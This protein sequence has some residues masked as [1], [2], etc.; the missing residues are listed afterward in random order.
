MTLPERLWVIR[1][2]LWMALGRHEAGLPFFRL[3]AAITGRDVRAVDRSTD[4]VIEGFP[5]SANTYALVAFRLAQRHPLRIAHHVHGPSQIWAAAQW[6]VPVL[7]LVREP[8]DA[9]ASLLVR[10]PRLS[11]KTC[12]KNYI[13][14]Y[15]P[16][17]E[18]RGA[19]VVGS[20]KMVTNSFPTVIR[21]LNRAFGTDFLE[22]RSDPDR[23]K[24]IF[25]AI[26]KLDRR[27]RGAAEAS[28][29]TVARPST[30]RDRLLRSTKQMLRMG[31][32]RELLEQAQSVFKQIME[33]SN[34]EQTR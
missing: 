7:L 3:Y 25:A 8:G 6:N 17:L 24:E 15:Q 16:L 29:L 21:Q 2:Q 23:V 10:Y 18:S 31:A 34:L 14:F 20:F 11:P 27:D 13:R 12:L 19:F 33:N 30:D 32:S 5:R 26:D 1:H 22:G 28:P 9:V 4:L